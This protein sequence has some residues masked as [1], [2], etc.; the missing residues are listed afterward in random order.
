MASTREKLAPFVP[1]IAGFASG[2]VACLIFYVIA[3]ERVAPHNR[4][5]AAAC[6]AILLAGLAVPAVSI[7][8]SRIG[9]DGP[10]EDIYRWALV[11]GGSSG[12][13]ALGVL[14]FSLA[15]AR[16][17]I[18]AVIASLVIVD[19]CAFSFGAL[20]RAL[21]KGLRSG[22]A[23]RLL[24]G[25]ALLLL[26]AAPF[27]SRGFLGSAAG[28]WLAKPLVGAS[29]FLATA[30]PWTSAS[31][32]WTFDPRVSN[33]LYRVWVGTDFPVHYPSWISCIAGHVLAGGALLGAA[34]LPRVFAA[35]RASSADCG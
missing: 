15:A 34:E 27:W 20:A 23:G 16:P 32:A 24:A 21:G 19:T 31:P 29:P 25:A 8:A 7:A 2:L 5:A 4:G 17:V 28:A 22:E 1:A 3:G 9:P 12:G 11:A 13:T 35:R 30:L 18:L 26:V 33:L 14:V 10:A 6:A